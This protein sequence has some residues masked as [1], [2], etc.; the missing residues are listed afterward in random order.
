MYLV[1][2]GVGARSASTQWH[3]SDDVEERLVV[4]FWYFQ[5]NLIQKNT[6]Q[7]TPFN[8]ENGW[9]TR[10][11]TLGEA[12]SSLQSRHTGFSFF[13]D[14]SMKTQASLGKVC[15]PKFFRNNY[16]MLTTWCI[17]DSKIIFGKTSLKVMGW[18]VFGGFPPFSEDLTR[19]NFGWI[20]ASFLYFQIENIACAVKPFQRKLTW[21]S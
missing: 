2:K 15:I 11:L 10:R 18:E 19:M 14:R 12:L 17:F 20:F 8:Q 16:I 13:S 9:L 5:E 3:A 4:L 6:S 1:R 21:S 7:T